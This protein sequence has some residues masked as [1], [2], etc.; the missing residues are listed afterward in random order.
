MS[1]IVP[2]SSAFLKASVLFRILLFQYFSSFSK[3]ENIW[4]ESPYNFYHFLSKN[5]SSQRIELGGTGEAKGIT[6]HMVNEDHISPN[7]G[8]NY[9]GNSPSSRQE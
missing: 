9:V 6:I 3:V 7:A 8:W 2:R 1:R 4:I 5:F